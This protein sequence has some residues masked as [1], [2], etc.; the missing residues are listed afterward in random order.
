MCFHEMMLCQVFFIVVFFGKQNEIATNKQAHL[1]S[2]NDPMLKKYA[3]VS[4]DDIGGESSALFLKKRL[5]KINTI[6]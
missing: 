3:L 5:A 1:L 2:I 6:F 4:S